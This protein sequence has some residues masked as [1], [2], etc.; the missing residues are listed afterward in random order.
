MTTTHAP[1]RKLDELV[2]PPASAS[3]PAG[4]D[5]LSPAVSGRP[6]N[7]G[8]CACCRSMTVFT[9]QADWLRDFYTCAHCGSVPRQRHLQTVLD[10][11]VSA[12]HDLVVHESSPSNDFL[13]RW[14]R[15]YSGSQYFADVPRGGERNGVRSEDVEDLTFPDD[16]IDLFIT[17]D[18][19]EHVF[20]PDRALQEIHRVLRPGGMH[21]FTA[22]KHRG[23]DRSR[24][25]AQLSAD[26]RVQHILNEE[27]HG[28][29][30]GDNK[31]LVTWDYGYDFEA[32]ASAWVGVGVQTHSRVDRGRG[33]DAEFNEVFV[34]RKPP[35]DPST[36]EPD[37]APTSP[38]PGRLARVRGALAHRLAP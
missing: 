5:D 14:C 25:R 38:P 29:P 12:W 31:A 16:S 34:I 20:R 4:T 23:L 10:E 2:T 24:Q 19:L 22:P 9:E 33:I 32:L 30:I 8:Y 37:T 28:N 15:D 17:Q 21:V 6:S 36:A 18:V 7:E 35:A 1:A 3:A 26:G 11:H 27:Y 13:S